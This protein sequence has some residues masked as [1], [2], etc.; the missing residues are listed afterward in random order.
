MTFTDAGLRR[1]WA[2]APSLLALAIAA[3]LLAG[4]KEAVK[5]WRTERLAGGFEVVDGDSLRLR[6]DDIRL[7]GI[8][9]PEL[10]QTCWRGEI[11]EACGRQA[12]AALA[13]LVAKGNV[14]CRSCGRDRYDRRL[15]VC[16]AGD[17]EINRAM[18]LAGNAVAYGAY[19]SE[20]E[21]ARSAKRGVWATRFERPADWRA[22]HPR[23]FSH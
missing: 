7:L 6:G 21:T 12:K 2:R 5:A 1:F 9:A 14:S 20:E 18:V 8:D 23:P 10:H 19:E 3:A 15:A 11:E 4:G 16:T 22:R 13:A 17:M